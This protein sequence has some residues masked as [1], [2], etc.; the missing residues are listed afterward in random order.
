MD[1]DRTKN[2]KT[3]VELLEYIHRGNNY[4]YISN[5]FT[6]QVTLFYKTL[7]DLHQSYNVTFYPNSDAK[8]AG[9]KIK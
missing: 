9:K 7:Y 5:I 6:L 3:L 8:D 2:F 4:M 1:I